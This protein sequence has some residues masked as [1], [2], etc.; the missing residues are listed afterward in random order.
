VKHI[1]RL[2]I[3]RLEQRIITGLLRVMISWRSR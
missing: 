1:V 2:P 3:G